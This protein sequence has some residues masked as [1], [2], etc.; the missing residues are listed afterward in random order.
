[1][2]AELNKRQ[3]ALG[4]VQAEAAPVTRQDSV[5]I[6]PRL[7]AMALTPEALFN[8]VVFDINPETNYPSGSSFVLDMNVWGINDSMTSFPEVRLFADQG[9]TLITVSDQ[10]RKDGPFQAI[11]QSLPTKQV[12]RVFGQITLLGS[13]STYHKIYLDDI[14]LMR[15]NYGKGIET[16]AAPAEESS[17]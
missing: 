12:K 7:S 17:N 15:Y 9:D 13:D 11:L 8:G 14:Q 10:I 4:D 16:T 6:W 1:M 3:K 5:D 2:L